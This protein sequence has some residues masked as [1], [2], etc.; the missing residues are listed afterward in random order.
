MT[1]PVLPLIVKPILEADCVA[2]E[3]ST[4]LAMVKVFVPVPLL[5]ENAV[6]LLDTPLVV[7]IS[8]PET[9]VSVS[10]TTMVTTRV[11]VSPRESVATTVS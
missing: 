5:L 11:P 8:D 1:T 7:S 2:P 4:T 10:L 6:E 3:E 9:I